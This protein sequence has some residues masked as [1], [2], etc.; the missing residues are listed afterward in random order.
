MYSCCVCCCCCRAHPAIAPSYSCLQQSR[1]HA[2]AH[3]SAQPATNGK[4]CCHYQGPPSAVSMRTRVLKKAFTRVKVMS[5]ACAHAARE[6]VQDHFLTS[7]IKYDVPLPTP[8]G[9]RNCAVK[10]PPEHPLVWL[11]PAALCVAAAL[12]GAVGRRGEARLT[13]WP[14]TSSCSRH[15]AATGTWSPHSFQPFLRLCL[16]LKSSL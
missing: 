14:D 7:Y 10:L 12:G 5:K 3:P 15:G 2:S 1:A 13:G 16:C 9:M 8:A 11:A 4:G 6:T